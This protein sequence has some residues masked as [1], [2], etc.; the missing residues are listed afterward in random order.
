MTGDLISVGKRQFERVLGSLGSIV[1]IDE[2][3]PGRAQIS[4]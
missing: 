4:H 1:L 3:N 2:S